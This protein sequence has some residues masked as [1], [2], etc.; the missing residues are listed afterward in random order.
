MKENQNFDKVLNRFD[1]LF[2]AFG[3]M[4]GWGWVVLSGTWISSA[5]SLGAMLAFV[6]G[7]IM[8]IFVGLTYAELASAMPKVGGEHAYVWRGIGPKASFIAS[9]AIALGYISVVAFEAVALPTVLEYLFPH[10]KIGYMWTIAG[11]DVY[12]TWVLVGVVGSIFITLINYM[13][14]KP[15]AIIQMV[16][17]TII[18]IIGLMLIFGSS[19][20]GDAANLQPLFVGGMAGIMGVIIMTPFMF[21]GFDV[22]PQAAEEMNVPPK[23]I[24]KILITAVVFAVIW[25]IAIIYGVGMSLDK[26]GL[27]NS[28]LATADAMGAAFGSDIFAKILILGG[29][30]GIMTSW[31]A[32]ILGGSRVIYAMAKSGMLPAWL[33]YLHPKYKTPSNAI[34]TIGV[35][36]TLCPLLGRPMLVWLVD[37]GGLAI[38][39]A[40]FLVALA[41]LALRKKEPEMERP[42]RAGRGSTIGWLALVLSFGF[43]ILYMPGMPA[44]LVWPY[45]WLIILGWWIIGFYYLITRRNNY[46]SHSE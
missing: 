6:V 7:G 26:E 14:V 19:V 31:N 43:I 36:A 44:A 30:A 17:T 5:G 40:Y 39:I 45:E 11:W 2:L 3:A 23:S 33:G 42:F 24:G 16:L 27:E 22:I 12:F 38:V 28:S 41:F 1:V 4:I 21:V 29:I 37:A 18:A 9:W 13:G 20:G 46:E 35:L 15:A 10:Y 34:L 25:Y 32:F 8:V